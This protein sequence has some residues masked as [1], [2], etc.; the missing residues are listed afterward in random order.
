MLSYIFFSFCR[1]TFGLSRGL[2]SLLH[3][4]AFSYPP[5][6]K[7]RQSRKQAIKHAPIVPLS[8]T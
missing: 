5:K 4:L 3:V 2:Q 8:P 1:Q 7:V 6:H